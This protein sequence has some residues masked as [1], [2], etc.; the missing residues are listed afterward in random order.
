M[1]RYRG[2]GSGPARFPALRF[3]GSPTDRPH[4]ATLTEAPCLV[5]VRPPPALGGFLRPLRSWQCPPVAGDAPAAAW[6]PRPQPARAG[7]EQ[8]QPRPVAMDRTWPPEGP[9]FSA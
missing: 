4:R 8:N 2:Y 9:A 3:N 1:A 7:D 5:G 6:P